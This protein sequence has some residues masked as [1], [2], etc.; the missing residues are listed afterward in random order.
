MHRCIIC[1]NRRER[2]LRFYESLLNEKILS[3]L[4]ANIKRYCPV[5]VEGRVCL[6]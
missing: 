2:D 1:R 6:Y 3:V 5:I 4:G